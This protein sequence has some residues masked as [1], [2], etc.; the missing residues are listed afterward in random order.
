MITASIM[1]TLKTAA[2]RR[3]AILRLVKREKQNKFFVYVKRIILK[4][5]EE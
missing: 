1:A 5:I 2:T 4:A 3:N